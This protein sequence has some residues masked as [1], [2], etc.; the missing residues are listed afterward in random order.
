MLYRCGVCKCPACGGHDFK[1]PD[2]TFGDTEIR[3]SACKKVTTI[4]AA[5]AAGQSKPLQR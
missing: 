1:G 5:E 2:Q 3:C 4:K